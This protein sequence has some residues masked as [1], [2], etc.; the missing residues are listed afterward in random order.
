MQVVGC[1]T[2]RYTVAQNVAATDLVITRGVFDT[3]ITSHSA[4]E[5]VEIWTSLPEGFTP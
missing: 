1:T 4:G 5:T 3:D 2:S